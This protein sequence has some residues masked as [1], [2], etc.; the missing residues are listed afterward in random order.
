MGETPGDI[1][2]GEVYRRQQGQDAALA[3]IDAALAA[4]PGL[5]AEQ[6]DARM[7]E[8]LA[9]LRTEIKAGDDAVRGELRLT[10]EHVDTLKRITY[11]AVTTMVTVA[12]AV[13]G[14]L[15]NLTGVGR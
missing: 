7:T 10:N 14:A 5:I 8:R 6:F 4:L 9:A 2:L 12:V 3:A 11:W 15:F 1:T 13:L